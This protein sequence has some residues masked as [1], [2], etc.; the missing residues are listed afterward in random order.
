MLAQM[1]KSIGFK[2]KGRNPAKGRIFELELEKIA[3]N[4]VIKSKYKEFYKIYTSD[5]PVT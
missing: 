1:V 5:S 3:E 4:R 2:E